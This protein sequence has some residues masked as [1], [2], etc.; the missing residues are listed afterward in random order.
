MAVPEC[1]EA[2][3]VVGNS[4]RLEGRFLTHVSVVRV[5]H[6]EVMPT[7]N[8]G[9]DEVGDNSPA[10]I[11]ARRAAFE[12]GCPDGRMTW[13]V[14]WLALQDGRAEYQEAGRLLAL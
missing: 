4:S 1:G 5:N 13:A 10:K 9:L 2:A 6:V 11:R 7:R 14:S 12:R 3:Q 8:I